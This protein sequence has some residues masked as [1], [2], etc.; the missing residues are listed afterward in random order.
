MI[1]K[2][3]DCVGCGF[4]CMHSACPHYS[5]KVMECD[6]CGADVSALYTIPG[7]PIFP[8]KH[9]C[10]DCI[11]EIFHIKGIYCHS[12]IQLI[13][14]MDDVYMWEGKYICKDCLMENLN[15][16]ISDG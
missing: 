10:E 13:E 14:D 3:S 8:Y 11:S 15:E 16:V 6:R 1:R 2:E 9:M 12:C 4:P 5:V 7:R